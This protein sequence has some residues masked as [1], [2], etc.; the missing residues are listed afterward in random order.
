MAMIREI[1]PN[2]SGVMASSDLRLDV[3]G[4]TT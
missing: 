3:V 1:D 2:M 4:Q